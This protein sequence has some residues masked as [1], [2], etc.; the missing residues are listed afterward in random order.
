MLPQQPTA[1][2]APCQDS[3]RWSRSQAVSLLEQALHHDDPPSLGAFAEEHAVPRST[4]HY[5][6]HRRNHLDTSEA[7]RSFFESAAGLDFLHGLVLA[8]H[9]AFHQ[10]GG[11]GIRPWSLFFELARLQPFLACSYGAQQRLAG[12]LADL[13]VEYGQTQRRPLAPAMPA[14]SISLCEDEN[15]H[16]GDPCLVAPCAMFCAM[17][18]IAQ[19][20]FPTSSSSRRVPT[21][22]ML[23]LGTERSSR[24]WKACP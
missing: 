12:A 8:A 23:T 19:G 13:I 22:A 15:F 18:N 17:Q 20:P 3:F 14:R 9:V 16:Q 5:W 21:N 24:A 10:T 11:S 2:V 7:L 6:K 4:L 1:D